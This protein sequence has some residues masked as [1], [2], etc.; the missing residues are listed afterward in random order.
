M[1]LLHDHTELVETKNGHAWWHPETIFITTNIR[2]EEWYDWGERTTAVLERRIHRI[3]DFGSVKFIL[4]KH[5]KDVTKEYKWDPGRISDN[6]VK[7]NWGP[8][9]IH[10]RSPTDDYAPTCKGIHEFYLSNKM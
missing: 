10:A 1:R 6:S 2:L 5:P 9:Q 8:Y 4:C 7:Y 3:L